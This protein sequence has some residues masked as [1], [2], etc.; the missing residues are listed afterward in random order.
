MSIMEVRLFT[1]LAFTL[2]RHDDEGGKYL[3]Q[4]AGSQCVGYYFFSATLPQP[5]LYFHSHTSVI[6]TSLTAQSPS[7]N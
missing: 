5:A 7:A 2:K 6:H 1:L 3:I 4:P